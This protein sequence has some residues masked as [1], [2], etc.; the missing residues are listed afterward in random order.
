MRRAT[1]RISA[2][3]A[4]LAL[5]PSVCT[6][7][8]SSLCSGAREFERIEFERVLDEFALHTR[9]ELRIEQFAEDEADDATESRN[10]FDRC[11]ERAGD[12]RARALAPQHGDELLIEVGARVP[13]RSPDSTCGSAEHCVSCVWLRMVSML[14]EAV[15]IAASA[16]ERRH[17]WVILSGPANAQI[18][19]SDRSHRHPIPTRTTRSAP[20]LT[21]TANCAC[22]ISACCRSTKPTSYAAMR[23][24]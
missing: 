13:P 10:R 21:P 6:R 3:P 18:H 19:N 24:T 7:L 12:R 9:E 4:M 2:S 20:L 8:T 23:R 15:R 17:A 11:S 22:S 1:P 5:V 14:A 16:Q